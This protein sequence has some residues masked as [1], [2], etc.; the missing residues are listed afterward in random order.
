MK[1]IDMHIY[2][3]IK[4]VFLMAIMGI[5]VI[6]IAV[7]TETDDRDINTQTNNNT[8]WK[9][10]LY[11]PTM[12]NK[13]EDTYFIVDCW[14][15]RVLY[16]TELDKNIMNWSTLTDESYVGGH[17]IASDGELYVLDNTDNS[18]VLA[19]RKNSTGDF[20]KI[21]AIG[22]IGGRPHY[23]IYDEENKYFYVIGSYSGKIY[24]FE[25]RNNDLFLVRID[26]ISEIKNTYVRSINIINGLLY[27]VSGGGKI[28]E[29]IISKE[30]FEFNNQ[31]DVPDELYG[32][33]QISKIGDYYYI[34]INTDKNGDVS[35]AD[36]I[37]TEKLENLSK[38]E[39]ESLYEEMDFGGQPY[40]ITEF[41]NSFYIT[42]I[43]A[44]KTNG[45]KK[46]DIK[47]NEIQ[48]VEDFYVYDD[49][50]SV[51]ENRY[52]SKY[53]IKEETDKPVEIVDLILFCGQSNMSG[54]GDAKEA[55]IVEYG[56][57]FRSI[58]DKTHLYKIYEPF[59]INENNSEGI[60]DIWNSTNELRKQG[61]LVSAFAN[62]YYE[63]TGVPIVGIS[64]SEGATS[65]SQW[66]PDTDKYNDII[67]RYS[68][69]R[70][71]FDNNEQYKIRNVFMVWC[72]GENDGDI[73]TDYDKYYQ[74]LNSIVESLVE[75]QIIDCCF[76]IA[77]G[78]KMGDENLYQEIRRAQIDLCNENENCVLVS[79][80]AKDF[81]NM[82]YMKDIYHYTQEGYN[83]LGDDAGRNAG[84]YADMIKIK[85]ETDE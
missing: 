78:N 5:L 30:G 25:N 70:N 61:G 21:K 74:S 8:E 63:T 39:Y 85:D 37:R 47:D 82:G 65:I 44:E 73:G 59:G 77:V 83:L 79:N 1:C 49:V 29:Y 7:V 66:L 46:F 67:K 51:S 9:E 75:A 24:V 81:C 33:N 10:E 26:D 53:G 15:H 64:C 16:N 4:E 6:A 22:N 38:Y 71:F 13:L 19:Y 3:K 40:F 36:I 23:V 35:K 17:T 56:Y 31:Y 14:N 54:K 45:I 42:Q 41:D 62:S 28:N 34:T 2:I 48:D 18:Q 72:Q 84:K 52:I 80:L 27:T 69:A 68:D 20:E 60:N 32:M 50:L 76:V 12:I 57:E 55:P 58:T 43:S 11:V